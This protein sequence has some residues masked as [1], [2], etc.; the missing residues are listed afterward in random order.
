LAV[1]LA[2]RGD[3]A[4]QGVVGSWLSLLSRLESADGRHE[5]ALALLPGQEGWL[6]LPAGQTARGLQLHA[7][8][9]AACSQGRAAAALDLLAQL[10]A[11]NP[12][13]RLQACARLDA[14]WLQLQLGQVQAASGHLQ[15]AGAW[16]S[17][18]PIGLAA[19]ARLHHAQ[20]QCSMAVHLQR[21]ALRQ[22]QGPPA[23]AHQALLQAYLSGDADLP[24]LPTLLSDSWL[25]ATPATTSR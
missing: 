21:L 24:V 7:L 25:P 2:C 16:P 11:L 6:G 17:E 18:H 1:A 10:I 9:A 13:S 14:A 5:E 15:A 19:R 3:A 23:G 20:G 4:S 12:Q 8:A 22:F